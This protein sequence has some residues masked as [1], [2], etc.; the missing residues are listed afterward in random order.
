MT[1][2]KF[3]GFKIS[4]DDYLFFSINKKETIVISCFDSGYKPEPA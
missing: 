1:D 2:E 4:F 3:D